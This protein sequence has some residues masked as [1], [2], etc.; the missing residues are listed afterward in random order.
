MALI[1]SDKVNRILGGIKKIPSIVV[2]FDGIDEVFNG[3]AIYSY[4]RVGDT[5]L[6]IDGSW[7]IGGTYLNPDQQKLLSF[8]GGAGGTTTKIDSKIDPDLGIG[9]TVTSMRVSI[10]DDSK[11]TLLALFSSYEFLARKARIKFSPDADNTLYPDDYTTVFRGIVDQIDFNSGMITMNIAHPDSKKRQ[12]IF[13][14]GSDQLDG[15]IGTSDTTITLSS[16]STFL[17]S[18]T[19]PDGTEDPAFESYV[20]INDEII[21]YT[22]ISGATLTGCLRGQLGTTAASHA[23]ED[24]VNSFYR[25]QDKAMNI[26]LKF[27]LSGWNG[28]FVSNIPITNITSANE[29]YFSGRDLIDEYGLTIGDYLTTTGSAT[30]SNNV[31]LKTISQ[32]EVDSTGNTT[33]TVNDVTFSSDLGTTATVA[34]RSRHDTLPSGLKM[35]PDEVDVETHEYFGG[36]FLSTADM[37]I[38]LKETIDNAKDFI[39]EELYRPLAAYSVPRETKSSVGYTIPPLPT[40]TPRTLD[41]S[42]VKRPES[43]TKVRSTGRNFYNTIFYKYFEDPIDD[44][45]LRATYTVSAE[46]KNQIILDAVTF[47]VESK[48]LRSG[49]II[50]SASE[51]RLRR[52][53]FAAAQI[54]GLKTTFGNGFVMDV[55]DKILVDGV[56]LKIPDEVTGS[57]TTQTKLYEIIRKTIDLKTGDVQLVVLDTNFN[58]DYRYGLISPASIIESVTD[59][60]TFT[61]QQSY[62]WNTFEWKKWQRYEGSTVRIRTADYASAATGIIESAGTNTISLVD[63]LSITPSA[64]MIMELSDYNDA[65]STIKLVYAFISSASGT[66]SFDDGEDTYRMI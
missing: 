48:G 55:G 9:E 53:K 20:R 18:I 26:A 28:P 5:G 42:N 63:N 38:Y 4:V 22:G 50:E 15:A 25:I 8:E 6:Y 52:Y 49:N 2:E 58:L 40:E 21:K 13:I 56:T 30:P 44:R 12:S 23:D 24:E 17:D 61:I 57:K 37:D 51:R 19:G 10:V 41:S 33:I 46:S 54:N 59:D 65:N 39:A 16:T 36:S 14:Q 11:S 29:L 47:K 62:S 27:M 1:V 45:F 35:T 3:T 34:F 64:N 60:K 32:I 66:G 43:I 7:T 31:S